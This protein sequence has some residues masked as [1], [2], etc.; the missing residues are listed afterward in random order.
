[1]AVDGKSSRILAQRLPGGQGIL[2]GRV[3]VASMAL[4]G[5]AQS[6]SDDLQ[7][8]LP[9]DCELGRTCVVQHY[10]DHDRS[11]GARD[12]ACGTLTYDGHDGTDFRVP[13]LEAQRAGVAVVA[14]AAGRV[15]GV[16]DGMADVSL[17]AIGDAA[18]KGRECGNGVTMTHGSGWETQYCHLA[19]G[20]LQ[21]KPGEEVT[22]GQALGRIGLSGKSEFPHLHF[23]VRHQG[24]I[25]DPFA[26]GAGEGSCNGGASLWTAAVRQ[27]H[28][29]R[30]GL[31]LNMGFAAGPV[32]MESIESGDAGKSSVGVDS[33]ALVAFARAIGLQAGDVARIVVTGPG[34]DVIADNAVEPLDR[35][36]A[37]HMLFAGKRRPA[38]GWARGT[39]RAIYTVRRGGAV[40]VE[41]RFELT[42]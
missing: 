40:V 25:V 15:K 7:L 27:S 20:S 13:T 39:Y 34:G 37:Q 12:Y 18:I 17:R 4:L 38:T 14:A 22:A 1:M 26:F 42:L 16:R 2:H 30:P 36:K 35:N 33:P 28:A 31:V 8:R 24:K 9:V 6:A 11:P 10:V 23:T 5:T 3:V 21:V 29:Y 41:Q 32:T 19:R